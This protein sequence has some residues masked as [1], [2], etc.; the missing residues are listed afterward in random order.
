MSLGQDDHETDAKNRT[1][2]NSAS[3]LTNLIEMVKKNILDFCIDQFD[4]RNRI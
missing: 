4:I 2:K 3:E 1:L